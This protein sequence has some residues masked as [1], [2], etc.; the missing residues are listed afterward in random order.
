MM[1]RGGVMPADIRNA[2]Q[3]ERVLPDDLLA[4]EMRDRRPEPRD[5]RLGL[6]RARAEA[7]R[8]EV[9]RQRV[10]PDV[11]H[12]LGIVRHGNAPLERRAADAQ[13]L[14]P[15]LDERPDLV[16]PERRLQKSGWSR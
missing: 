9:V 10:E 11:H 3:Y 7:E 5:A 6:R 16:Q 1:R 14:E 8:G 4:D 12:V 15:G 2:G 13:I